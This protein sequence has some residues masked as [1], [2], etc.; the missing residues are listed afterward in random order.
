MRSIL[1]I[2]T[3]VETG[4]NQV[5]GKAFCLA[6]I[7]DQ[8][9]D[10]PKT[11]CVPCRIFEAYVAESHLKDRILLEMN[12][13]PFE[14]M[15]WEEIWDISLRIR[16]LFLTTPIPKN[17]RRSLSELL[18]RHYGKNPVAIRSSAPGED[19][20]STSFAGLHDSYLNVSGTDE[21]LKHIKMVWS[22][23]YSDAALLYRKELGLD[24]HTS[25]MAV[26]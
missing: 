16:N 5:G 23:L 14:Q 7:H 20:E 19:D 21:I 17:I 6:R 25:Q 8:G 12:R 10:V 4:I 18:S 1:G 9:F 11:F 26:V 3:F 24:I 13:K 15:R 22:S 2:D